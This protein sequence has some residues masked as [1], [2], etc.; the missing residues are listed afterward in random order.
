MAI[1]HRPRVG[2]LLE[3]DFGQWQQIEKS[4]DYDKHLEPEMRKR[5]MVMVLN[6]NLDG[7]SALVVPIS[8]TRSYGRQANYH[9]LID[10]DLINVTDFYDKRERWA[11]AEHSKVVSLTRLYYIFDGAMKLNQTLPSDVVT[12]IQL[13][14]IK[15]INAQRILDEMQNRIDELENEL[16]SL[17]KE[18]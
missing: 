9:H 10:T 17:K 11:L 4:P 13:K 18:Q 3:C 8:S 1:K 12:K 14:V 7:K 16:N 6:A 15:A 5:R 2:E